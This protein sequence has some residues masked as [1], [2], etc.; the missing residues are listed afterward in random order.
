MCAV[1]R[2]PLVTKQE[3]GGPYAA[4]DSVYVQGHGPARI[5]ER[6]VDSHSN[7]AYCVQYPDNSIADMPTDVL[8]PHLRSNSEP[9]SPKLAGTSPGE[10]DRARL[11]LLRPAMDSPSRKLYLPN[12]IFNLVCIMV[13]GGMLALPYAFRVCGIFVGVVVLIIS[14]LAS[15]FTIDMLISCSRADGSDSY[16]GVVANALGF[17][18][19]QFSG[20][21]MFV[22]TFMCCV[23]Y[24]VLVADL[25]SPIVSLFDIA[26]TPVHRNYLLIGVVLLITPLALQRHLS[27]LR[28]MNIVGVIMSLSVGCILGYVALP[29]IGNA[30]SVWIKDVEGLVWEL[31]SGDVPLRWFPAKWSD[32]MYAFP[33]FGLSFFAH[34]NVIPVQTEM[35][36]PTRRRVYSVVGSTT[37]FVTVF[38]AFVGVTGYMYAGDHTCGNTLLN[39]PGDSSLL[40]FARIGLASCLANNVPLLVIACR[41]A[42]YRLIMS[43][44]VT[45]Q[46]QT[47]DRQVSSEKVHVY[48]RESENLGT[49]DRF[50]PKMLGGAAAAEMPRRWQILFTSC[51]LG[52]VTLF[53]CLIPSILTVWTLLGCTTGFLITFILPAAAW[54][55][56]RGKGARFAK[57][58]AAWATLV[59]FSVLCVCCTAMALFNASA[60]PCPA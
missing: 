8:M 52:V 10:L 4:G 6:R 47:P 31:P 46:D 26:M 43:F 53:A 11:E 7:L 49:L 29:Q 13:G 32:L 56:T 30:H 58:A 40:A 23:A 21:L 33:I 41:G 15:A 14:G 34:C 1:L 50:M 51:I 38:Y 60:A 17:R 22:L 59:V 35:H 42:F 3:N 9:L 36:W 18:A 44:N 28:F 25:L 55:S 12:A 2:E 48:R 45:E 19:Q 54:L 27:A 16:E 24:L 39:Y 20:L 37:G 57:T 5:L